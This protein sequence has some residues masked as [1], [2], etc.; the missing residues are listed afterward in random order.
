MFVE[1]NLDCVN[2][3][4]VLDLKLLFLNIALTHNLYYFV[5]S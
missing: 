3:S 5:D 2:F 4:V 1:S